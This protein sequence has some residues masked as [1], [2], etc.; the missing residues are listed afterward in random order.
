MYPAFLAAPKRGQKRPMGDVALILR[1]PFIDT[2]LVGIDGL[3]AA[4]AEKRSVLISRKHPGRRQ[5]GVCIWGNDSIF[6]LR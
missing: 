6:Q 3:I 1:R 2:A 5:T 4:A